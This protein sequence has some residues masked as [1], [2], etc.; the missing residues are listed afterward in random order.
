MQNPFLHWVAIFCGCILACVLMC[1]CCGKCYRRVPVNYILLVLFTLCVSYVVAGFCSYFEP[2][3]VVCA[4]VTTMSMVVG[5]TMLACFMKEE[6]VG[7]CAGFAVALVFTLLPIIFFALIWP[8]KLLVIAIEGLLIVLFSIYIIIDT[9][10][11]MKKF[12]YDEYIIAA[13]MLYIDI[14]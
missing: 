8:S 6:Q 10:L 5:L 12:T 2:V 13:M 9:R 3:Y 14:I 4:A 7:Y 11:I 1:P